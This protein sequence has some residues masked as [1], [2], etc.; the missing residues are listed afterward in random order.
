MNLQKLKYYILFTIYLLLT[1]G[2]TKKAET[3]EEM[4]E[5]IVGKWVCKCGA[6]QT[7]IL[8]GKNYY[9]IIEFS[10]DGKYRYINDIA[11]VNKKHIISA[12]T[13]DYRFPNYSGFITFEDS[14]FYEVNDGE[15]SFYKDDEP[16]TVDWLGFN[17]DNEVL[18]VV[19]LLD[20]KMILNDSYQ[21]EK[22]F[23]N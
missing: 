22:Y 18:D 12:D 8:G 3:D 10:E 16:I 23:K 5:M 15:I 20:N 7:A 13:A 21:D 17:A 14:V 1:T 6:K 11:S 4:R 19:K 9:K 2:C